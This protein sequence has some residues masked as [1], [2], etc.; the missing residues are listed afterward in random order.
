M[1]LREG[2]RTNSKLLIFFQDLEVFIEESEDEGF[3]FI[4]FGSLVKMSSM[5]EHLAQT[6]F[7]AIK[8]FKTRFLWRWDGERPNNLPANVLIRKWFP[9]QDILGKAA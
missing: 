4:S 6:M 5:P 3:I 8:D 2:K 1:Q 7:D 9:Q